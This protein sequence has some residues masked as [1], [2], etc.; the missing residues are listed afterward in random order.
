MLT[1]E[2]FRKMELRV[3]RVVNVEDHPQADRLYILTVDDGSTQKK[4]VAGIK[5]YYT[6]ESL[7]NRLFI[8]V[9]NMEP[10]TIRGV[11]SE[12][13]LLAAK[14]GQT[15]SILTVEKDVLVGSPVS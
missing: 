3:A 6:K 7:Q 10:A 2:E 14:D 11:Q 1:L 12:G 15:L 4:I 9:N 8:L 13:M 5:P